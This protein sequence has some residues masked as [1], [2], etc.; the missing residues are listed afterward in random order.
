VVE[1]R[2][3]SL[4]RDDFYTEKTRRTI[5]K[6]PVDSHLEEP[7]F[8]FSTMV[9]CHI[10]PK[11]EDFKTLTPIL[12]HLVENLGGVY[13]VR[14]GTIDVRTDIATGR[15]IT[16][17]HVLF[18]P[19][20]R[21]RIISVSSLCRDGMCTCTFNSK[22]CW[23]TDEYGTT[24]ARGT[25]SRNQYF[26]SINVPLVTHFEFAPLQQEHAYS[27]DRLASRTPNT[28][29]S[30]DVYTQYS[31]ST[32]FELRLEPP[33]GIQGRG[34]EGLDPLEVCRRKLIRAPSQNPGDQ[35]Q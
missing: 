24:V 34:S 30:P 1:V 32:T 15:K 10:S 4:P 28:P 21:E 2:A 35:K 27:A 17:Q 16:L 12:P 3:T 29:R 20:A 8:L 22:S 13:A 6:F 33:P 11:I 25:V 5:V 19:F 26:L 7:L 14:Q 9:T 18:V 31:L 23:V